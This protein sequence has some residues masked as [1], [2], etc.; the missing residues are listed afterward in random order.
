MESIGLVKD[1]GFSN[2]SDVLQTKDRTFNSITEV[3][4]TLQ[5]PEFKPNEFVNFPHAPTPPQELQ[6]I[7]AG[8]ISRWKDNPTLM[9]EG[10]SIET[11]SGDTNQL[12][13]LL[14]ARFTFK[15]VAKAQIRG[16]TGLV[17]RFLRQAVNV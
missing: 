14:L 13:S 7:A 5:A 2:E 10:F 8:G 11:P 15:Y 1:A 4:S 12:L 3:S 9:I 6:Y 17:W 16:S